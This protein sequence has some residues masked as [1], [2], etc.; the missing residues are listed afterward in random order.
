MLI[1]ENSSFAKLGVCEP[2]R[3]IFFGV[4]GV[5]V[6]PH[7]IVQVRACASA[8]AADR[9]DLL[10]LFD[11]LASAYVDLIEVRVPGDVSGSV[12]QSD[13]FPVSSLPA[14]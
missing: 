6:E 12:I 5:S 13:A 9:A 2:D 7:L 14:A 1:I 11:R 4:D 3:K 10:A 8:C